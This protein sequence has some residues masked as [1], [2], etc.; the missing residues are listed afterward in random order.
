[1]RRIFIANRGEIAARIA[2]TALVLGIETV[3]IAA[4]KRTP[5]YL[6]HW[7]DKFHYVDDDSS[8]YLDIDALLTIAKQHT[9]DALHPGYG[10]LAENAEFA[11]ATQAA[12]ITWI[13][14]SADAIA[15]MGN[16]SAARQVAIAANVPVLE[17]IALRDGRA[18]N[19]SQRL[20][21][22]TETHKP[23]YIVKPSAG[24]G[25]KG[26]QMVAAAE[27]LLAAVQTA[28]RE[29][30]ALYQNPEVLVE[31]Y[32][33]AP[34]HIE[35]Q[36]VGDHVGK[37]AVYGER[38]CSVQRRFQKI[39][40]EA[41][42]PN[43]S[44]Q[45]RDNLAAAALALA[46]Q[47]SYYSTGTV[48]FLLDAATG[49]FYFLEMNTRLQVEHTVTEEVFGV[50]LVAMQLDIACGLE[51]QTMLP[52]H[53]GHSIQARLY[54]EDA[55]RDFMPTPGHLL[56][57]E[58][59]H[60]S[61][62]RWEIGV[63]AGE[64]LSAGFDP[65]IAKLI[66]SAATRELA[67]ARLDLALRDSF[68]AGITTNIQFLRK[69]LADEAFK[70]G[71]ITTNYVAQNLTRLL[72]DDSAGKVGDTS[73]AC[74]EY[75][76]QRY[77]GSGSLDEGKGIA[78]LFRSTTAHNLPAN[79]QIDY[80]ERR[81][82]NI[83]YGCGRYEDKLLQYVVHHR[84]D[85]D[86]LVVNVAGNYQRVDE[87]EW[88]WEGDSQHSS[89]TA[90]SLLRAPLPGKVATVQVAAGDKVQQGDVCVSLLSMK[91]EFAVKAEAD[92]EVAKVQVQTGDTVGEGD[93]LVVFVSS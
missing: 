39:I 80:E 15:T 35:V 28:S 23:P 84:R 88:R 72:A 42:A 1:M 70:Q 7:V 91:M 22:Y 53:R 21:S 18:D 69:V 11:Q 3:A 38:E 64:Q 56:A 41:P 43:L 30:E 19:A 75:L 31:R 54:A 13:G 57:F 47:V 51:L 14:P 67:I 71:K 16:K 25:G 33:T 63:E 59:L 36:I 6:A 73:T 83:L 34:R 8:L 93:A 17:G 2:Q 81:S 86:T 46:K 55:T 89:A 52:R 9:C 74:V 79:L 76:R 65:M 68:V 77:F 82:G 87:S 50:D 78:E 5:R 48:E 32:I 44:D 92:G 24:G 40:E 85:C 4:G 29:A 49:D 37:V 61:G 66:S 26:M 20:L 60:G 12:G 27:D 58:P 90:D 62:L 45:Q 10:F